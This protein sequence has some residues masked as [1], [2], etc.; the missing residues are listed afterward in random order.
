[1]P[2]T[3][4]NP[5]SLPDRPAFQNTPCHSLQEKKNQVFN[6]MSSE[7]AQ[8]IKCGWLSEVRYAGPILNILRKQVWCVLLGSELKCYK[9]EHDPKIL[10]SVNLTG[11]R[12]VTALSKKS[13]PYSF[14]LEPIEDCSEPAKL[15]VFTATSLYELENWINAINLRLGGRNIVDVALDRLAF[16][17]A[18]GIFSPPPSLRSSG[19]SDSFCP[20]ANRVVRTVTITSTDP[21]CDSL[22][23]D[24]SVGDETEMDEEWSSK[25]SDFGTVSDGPFKILA[26]RP[27]LEAFRLELK[28]LTKRG[29]SPIAVDN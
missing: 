10:T 9:S 21:R 1:M 13:S 27:D 3:N 16:A 6:N 24:D 17:D 25:D 19:S 11:Y 29:Q 28:A 23:K 8:V 15:R 7:P 22:I 4:I 12:A 5:I 26:L 20:S 18:G 2:E 14:E